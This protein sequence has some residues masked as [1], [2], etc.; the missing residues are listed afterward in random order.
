MSNISNNEK[1][2][3][4]VPPLEEFKGVT[5]FTSYGDNSKTFQKLNISNKP[6]LDIGL[7]GPVESLNK[8][9]KYKESCDGMIVNIFP[10]GTTNL[11]P[12][13]KLRGVKIGEI[14]YDKLMG[15]D[16]KRINDCT[17]IFMIVCDES[18]L[19]NYN[20]EK[21]NPALIFI[22]GVDKEIFYSP[23]KFELNDEFLTKSKKEIYENSNSY[24]IYIT[25]YIPYEKAQ[26]IFDNND[27]VI[28][29]LDNKKPE[30]RYN[31]VYYDNLMKV[32]NTRTNGQ[33]LVRNLEYRSAEYIKNEDFIPVILQEIDKTIEMLKSI[34][35]AKNWKKEKIMIEEALNRYLILIKKIENK[36]AV[37]F[38][39]NIEPAEKR[40]PYN[41][42]QVCKIKVK[43]SFFQKIFDIESRDLIYKMLK[44]IKY[45]N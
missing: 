43:R 41:Y 32:S 35:K 39:N 44:D 9:S 38:N 22:G 1:S 26:E 40:L 29:I 8:E 37:Y 36:E 19:V 21:V 24:K 15:L 23:E 6:S 3:K 12:K 14:F 27:A 34:N 17:L 25:E 4:K 7:K 28:E 13:S 11:K 33:I 20:S 16:V 42:I 31:S 18:T 30:K 10:D 2:K 45:F 5:S